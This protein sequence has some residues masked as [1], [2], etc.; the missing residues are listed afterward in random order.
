MLKSAIINFKFLSC[1]DGVETTLSYNRPGQPAATWY[2]WW[3]L[4]VTGFE[5]W[6]Y[7]A[8]DRKLGIFPPYY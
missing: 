5:H 2:Q 8:S 4:V 7:L 6:K 1:L 3:H